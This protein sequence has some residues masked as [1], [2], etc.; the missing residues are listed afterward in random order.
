MP[1]EELLERYG[2]AGI[3][4]NRALASMKKDGGKKFLS[5]VIRAKPDLVPEDG[6]GDAVSLS[7]ESAA[8][9]DSPDSEPSS[10][11]KGEV[12]VNLADSIANG[13]CKEDGGEAKASVDAVVKNDSSSDVTAADSVAAS[14][15]QENGTTSGA[16]CDS[17]NT[18]CGE[19]SGTGSDVA[20]GGAS[21][22]A[23]C[24]DAAESCAE[25]GPSSSTSE[26]HN[27]LQCLT[28]REAA[29]FIISVNSVCQ[30]TTFARRDVGSSYLH[31][32]RQYG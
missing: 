25:A 20:E 14:S 13:F 26:V 23:A 31:I 5:P 22:S 32:S 3:L 4:V 27:S 28:T 17:S 30:T 18:V 16:A 1:I 21:S 9:T 2:G 11:E 8:E 6:S 10:S 19:G 7:R 12:R 29:W 15:L 24:D